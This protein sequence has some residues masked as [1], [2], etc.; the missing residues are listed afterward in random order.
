M[1]AALAALGDLKGGLKSLEEA[2]GIL[3]PLLSG[4]SPLP[5]VRG[6]LAEAYAATGEIQMRLAEGARL[7]ASERR[8][9][10]LEAKGSLG[11]SLEL[12]LGLGR[13]NRLRLS[14]AGRIES[15][16]Q[17]LTLCDVKLVTHDE[18]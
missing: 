12:W 14:D 2:V 1:G 6:S 5:E 10:L 13:E 18:R 15:L 17:A 8:G 7:P 11:R 4:P 9:R 16:N 3:A